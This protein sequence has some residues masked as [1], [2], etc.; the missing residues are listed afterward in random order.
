MSVGFI[1]TNNFTLTAL[2]TFMDALRL[3]ADDGDGSRQIRCRWTIM[4]SSPEPV[5]SSCGI[6]VAR[7]EAF[8][9]P[10]QFD[11][12]V[13]VGGL[14]H[15]GPQLDAQA[16]EYLRTAAA[17]G[18]GLVGVC[19][20]S[21][22]LS[23][24]GLMRNRRCCVSWYHYRD[25][26][27]EFPDHQPVAE[28]LYVVDRDRITCAGGA[29]VAD[30]A[31]F[32]IER[33]LGSACA[34][35]TMHIMLIDKARPAGQSQPQP[36]TAVEGGPAIV[37]DRVRRA[38]LLMEQNLTTPLT[39]EQIS[40]RLSVSTRQF[41]RLFREATGMSPNSF[42]RILRLRYGHWL[43]RN[44]TRSVTDIAQET[45]FSDCAHFS[46]QF[47]GVYGVSPS[48]LRRD[49]PPPGPPAMAEGLSAVTALALDRDLV[50]PDRRLFE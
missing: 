21:F 16:V 7:W 27:E 1:L 25:Y 48:G 12:L 33:H 10:R 9:D 14:L 40:S 38:L 11:Y 19:T 17:Q 22:V 44:S 41:E 37:N 34:Q 47:R 6:P 28:Q 8:Q 32:L 26:L 24:A 4:G 29:G 36:P 39:V 3:A 45:G 50:P 23:R 31:A 30:L 20:G 13:V 5:K 46:R 49:G 43:L 15:A 18:V 42:Y 2:A 35:K